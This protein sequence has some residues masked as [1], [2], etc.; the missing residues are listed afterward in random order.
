MTYLAA[1]GVAFVAGAAAAFVAFW[2]ISESG[3]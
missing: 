3:R 2:I 1:Y